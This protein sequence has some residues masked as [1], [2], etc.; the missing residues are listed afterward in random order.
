MP[1][2]PVLSPTASQCRLFEAPPQ[3]PHS[4]CLPPP[5]S[6]AASC[7]IRQARQLGDPPYKDCDSPPRHSAFSTPKGACAR[8]RAE[9]G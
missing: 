7:V 5:A 1:T 2:G 4:A 3:I 8:A 6:L 9:F